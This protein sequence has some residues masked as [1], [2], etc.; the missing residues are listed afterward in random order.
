MNPKM[1]RMIK[2]ANRDVSVSKLEEAQAEQ[3]AEM[4]PDDWGRPSEDRQ[5][6]WEWAEG[7]RTF[8]PPMQRVPDWREELQRRFD[9]WSCLPYESSRTCCFIFALDCIDA[10]C[11]TNFRQMHYG[12]WEGAARFGQYIQKQG[13][14]DWLDRVGTRIA[15]SDVQAGDVYQMELVADLRSAGRV[16]HFHWGIA[17]DMRF[18]TMAFTA[19]GIER[20]NIAKTL[21]VNEGKMKC[22]A[23]GRN[24]H[25]NHGA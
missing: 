7:Q 6:I 24:P 15:D 9:A 18:V 5:T 14:V 17:T 23:I 21:M 16:T 8:P 20:L 22:W 3:I 4:D 25:S 12:G 19:A 2:R 10:M 11:G 1:L 13:G